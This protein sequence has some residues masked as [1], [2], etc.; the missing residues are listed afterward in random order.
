MH[1]QSIQNLLLFG[2]MK[3]VQQTMYHIT[4]IHHEIQ[5]KT[6]RLS[7]CLW[8][9]VTVNVWG[10]SISD[11]DIM[12]LELE[13]APDKQV[14]FA[15]LQHICPEI[16][17]KMSPNLISSL[18]HFWD[19]WFWYWIHVFFEGEGFDLGVFAIRH[20]RGFM[21]WMVFLNFYP[22]KSKT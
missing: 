3:E 16:M 5:Q 10:V 7:H 12:E 9:P 11:D 21:S 6:T 22:K 4:T 19:E 17:S 20:S 14:S 13:M 18:V 15:Q 1:I 8:Q 2:D